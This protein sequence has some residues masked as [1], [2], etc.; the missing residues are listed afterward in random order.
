[1]MTWPGHWLARINHSGKGYDDFMLTHA[2]ITQV[3]EQMILASQ[4][5]DE[6]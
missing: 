5:L 3:A 4:V 1:M 6:D 2:G